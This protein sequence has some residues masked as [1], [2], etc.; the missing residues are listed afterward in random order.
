MPQKYIYLS[1]HLD[2]AVLSCGGLIFEQ[3]RS[4][5]KVEIWTITAGIPDPQSMPEFGKVLNQRWGIGLEMLHTRREEDRAACKL[6]GAKAVHLDWLDCIYRWCK[7]GD[8]LIHDD[9][10]LFAAEPEAT[11]VTEIAA[12]LKSHVTHGAKL[13]SPLGIGDHVDH[14]LVVQAVAQS[15]L[16]GLYYADYPYVSYH[17]EWSPRLESRELRRI[18]AVITGDGVE[19]WQEAVLCNRSQ[20]GTFWHNDR[21]ARLAIANYCAGGGGRLWRL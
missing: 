4:G 15:G 12:Y 14:R 7:D 9:D 21:E 18:P 10:E 11:L 16:G 17:F 19:A 1:P 20:L 3:V 6:L 2:D 13:I 8:A 5:R